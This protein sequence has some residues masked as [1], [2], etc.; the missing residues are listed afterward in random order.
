MMVPIVDAV[1]LEVESVSD[2]DDSN[3]D[4]DKNGNQMELK[5]KTKDDDKLSK[6]YTNIFNLHKQMYTYIIAI[7]YMYVRIMCKISET[8]KLKICATC[9]S[10]LWRMQPTPAELGP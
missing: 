1:L 9:F 10:C 3:Y 8:A 7:F 6:R 2:D 5:K 4:Q